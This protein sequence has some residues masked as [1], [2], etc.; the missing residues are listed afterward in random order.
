MNHTLPLRNKL[1]IMFS[2]MAALFLVALDQTI[3]STALGKIVEEFN[4]FESLGWIVTAYMLTTT[5]TVPI[6]GKLSDLFGRRIMLVL[7]VVIFTVGSLLSATAGSI[8]MLIW[9]RALQGIGGGFIT[10]NAFTIVGDLFVARERGKWQ[11]LIGAVF[12]ISSL[13]GPLLG[14]FLTETHHF[15][16]MTTDWRWTFFINIP[17][18]IA[19]LA[20][21]AK[22]CPPL[23]H[24]GTKKVRIDYLGAA[25]LTGALSALV[26]AVDNTDTI[27]KGL[28]DATGM[29]VGVLQAILYSLAAL[30]A[31]GFVIAEHYS[32]EPVLPLEF[33]RH[34]NFVLVIA[35]ALLF[36]GAFLGA[37]IYITQFNQ[38]VFGASP[39]ESGLM[40]LPL[41]AGLMTTSIGSGQV[42]ARTGKYKIQMIIG[43]AIGTVA[44]LMLTRLTP[45]SS[46]L[47]EAVMLV[48][49][50]GGFG[51]A[52]PVMN[53][54]VQTEFPVR[55]LGVATSST[56]LFRGLGSTIGVAILGTV[57]THGITASLSGIQDDAYLASLSRSPAAKSIGDFR[58]TNTLLNL[59]MPEIK[60]KITDGMMQHMADLP[61]PQ[62][63][64]ATEQFLSQQAAYASKITHAYSNGL[65]HIFATSAGL[66]LAATACAIFITEKELR[67]ATDSDTPSD[68]E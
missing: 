41:I 62:R 65:R 44:L 20:F 40:I 3:I 17:V 51:V 5:V 27:F 53:L 36:G 50:G 28:L 18:A 46:Y 59:N 33:F 52:M 58:D 10:A 21:L 8:D 48:I 23:K 30:L 2:V 25:L 66:M 4:A 47:Y 37:I 39:T 24:T 45:E 31:V 29:Q 55:Q 22:F 60:H 63:Q 6:A 68:N 7:G 64:Q 35:I 34:K 32:K 13:I 49:L 26:L 67:S 57:M 14:G 16:G 43:M 54:I 12:G 15:L 19:A 56:Q 9:S 1:I 61:E 42:V 38:Q 11:G